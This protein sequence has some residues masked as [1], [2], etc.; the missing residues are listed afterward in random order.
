M[1]GLNIV[2]LHFFSLLSFPFFFLFFLSSL[3]LL[4][5][6]S[7]FFL[8]S[9]STFVFL[10]FPAHR[11]IAIHATYCL[12]FLNT[13]GVY[14]CIYDEIQ[15]SHPN[16]LIPSLISSNL[17]GHLQVIFNL[18]FCFHPYLLRNPGSRPTT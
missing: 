16:D 6:F 13:Y 7:F 11:T 2:G 4:Y 15:S 12:I 1:L 3:Y 14:K 9:S 17:N 18:R 10:L 8:F 5:I